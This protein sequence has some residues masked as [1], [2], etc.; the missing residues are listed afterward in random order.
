MHPDPLHLTPCPTGDRSPESRTT[1]PTTG[2]TSPLPKTTG[3]P[4]EGEIF[5]C[6]SKL[7]ASVSG[8]LNSL[9]N[10]SLALAAL[11]KQP[12]PVRM[13]KEELYRMLKDQF[14]TPFR[15]PASIS[16]PSQMPSSSTANPAHDASTPFRVPPSSMPTAEAC[17]STGAVNPARLTDSRIALEY[18][19]LE[20][21]MI[22]AAPGLVQ[23]IG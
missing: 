23:V 12:P 10:F 16:P 1:P 18:F 8:L 14:E 3:F 11:T 2:S 7:R 19:R 13:S 22:D 17:L 21:T 4:S 15:V 6:I 5:D 20:A 9:E